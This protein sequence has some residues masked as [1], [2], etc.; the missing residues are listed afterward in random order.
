M[1]SRKNNVLRNDEKLRE[2]RNNMTTKELTKK[3]LNSKTTQTLLAFASL[4]LL[5][6]IFSLASPYFFEFNNL[7]GI[8]LASL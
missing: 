7:I 3:R 5:I 8:L 4:I 6:L 2:D 1:Q